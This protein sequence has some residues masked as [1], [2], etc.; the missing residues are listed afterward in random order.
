MNIGIEKGRYPVDALTNYS[1]IIRWLMP[2][3]HR[4]FV[5]SRA[6]RERLRC[7]RMT[8][9]FWLASCSAARGTAELRS[10]GQPRA[11]VPT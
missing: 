9:A 2:L 7:L 8:W 5:G 3:M 11:G 10:A 6:L 1:Y 4:S